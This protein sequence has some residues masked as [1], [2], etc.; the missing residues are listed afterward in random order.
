[1][2]IWKRWKRKGVLT[3]LDAWKNK[4]RG[5]M[6][7]LLSP[8]HHTYLD[9]DHSH[10]SMP[11]MDPSMP[12]PSDC[13]TPMLWNYYTLDP[14][15]CIVFPWWHSH[16]RKDYW[17]LSLLVIAFLGVAFE[18]LRCYSRRLDSKIAASLGNGGSHRRRAS[19][20]PT[21][22]TTSSRADSETLLSGGR[23]NREKGWM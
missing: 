8:L 11:G 14:T 19:I 16:G 23:R 17:Y 18:G 15:P 6:K 12:M 20:L 1:M 3:A 10:H 22:G 13:Q 21:S 4:K 7:C 5:K 2:E 9:M